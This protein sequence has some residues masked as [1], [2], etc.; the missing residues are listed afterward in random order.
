MSD[1]AG[2]EKDIEETNLE[3]ELDVVLIN[4]LK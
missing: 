2:N 1:D 3:S 4:N